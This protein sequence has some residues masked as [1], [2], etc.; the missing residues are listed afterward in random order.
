MALCM[1]CSGCDLW[2][3]PSVFVP[4]QRLLL[5]H[6]RYSYYRTSLVAQYSFYKSFL[7]CFLQVCIRV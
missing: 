7:F 5:V 4:L 1:V 3:P 6:G 2:L